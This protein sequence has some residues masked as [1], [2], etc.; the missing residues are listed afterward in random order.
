VVD[1][2]PRGQGAILTQVSKDGSNCIIAYASRLLTDV[3]SRYSQ[4]NRKAFAITWAILHFHLYVIGKE[5]TVITDHKPLEG[6]FNKPLIQPPARIERLRKNFNC[7]TSLS[8]ISPENPTQLITCHDTLYRQQQ[9][10][11]ESNRLL[12]ITLIQS[13]LNQFKN[14]F[15]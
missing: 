10:Q 5:F 15:L 1:A 6:I 7:M 3:E 4:K 11:Q 8:F 9:S 14:Q 13:V 2:S 12:K